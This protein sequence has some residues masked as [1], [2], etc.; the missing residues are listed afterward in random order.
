[1]STSAEQAA[2]PESTTGYAWVHVVV[3]ALAMVATLPGRTQGLGLI[4]EPL[5]RDLHLDRVQYA[6]INLAATLL[7]GLFCL[8]CGWLIDR[9][10]PR[11]VLTGVL[12]LL[13]CVVGLMSRAEPDWLAVS[14]AT[15]WSE[16]ALTLALG[17]FVLVLLTRGLGQS[18]L[19]VVSL[20]LM[21]K[22]AGRRSGLAYGVYS[23]VIALGFMGAFAACKAT[24]EQLHADWRFLW[25]GVGMGVLVFALP[26]AVLVRPSLFRKGGP[27]ER[28]DADEGPSL[29]LGEALR[30]PAFWVFGLGTSVYGLVAAGVSLFNQSILEERHFNRDVFLTITTITPLIGLGSNL[31]TGWLARWLPLGRLLAVAMLVL[32][33]A[34]ALFPLVTTLEQV[35]AYAVAMGVSGGMVTV[36]FFAVWARAFG[37]AHLGKIQGAAQMLTVLASALGPLLLAASKEGY[38]S[39]VPLFYGLAPVCALLGLAAWFTPAGAA[40][41]RS[42]AE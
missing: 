4:T 13:G 23:A 41:S 2:P 22:S 25:A 3:A 26:A 42:L 16:G 17:L 30:T 27:E 31:A 20:A 7:G 32:A 36:I 8:P 15:P 35:Y 14:V 29:T 39:Y 11:V 33:S 34:L 5:L 37:K 6:N 1:M 12:V 21:G 9:L 24:L 28:S 38:G 40:P 10:G 18:A 19:S